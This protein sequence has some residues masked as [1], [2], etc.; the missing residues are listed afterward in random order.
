M[1]LTQADRALAAGFAGEPQDLALQPALPYFDI[2]GVDANG[3]KHEICEQATDGFAA[4]NKYIALG[5]RPV[6]ARPHPQE[7]TYEDGYKRYP[8]ALHPKAFTDAWR[9]WQGAQADAA[10]RK[11]DSSLTDAAKWARHDRRALALQIDC[12]GP[13]GEFDRYHQLGGL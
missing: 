1:N 3:L 6:S 8:K 7:L 10:E 11:F 4:G 13:V 12:A 9:G 5:W 2:T